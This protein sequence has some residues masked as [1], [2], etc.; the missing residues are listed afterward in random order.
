VGITLALDSGT[1][2]IRLVEVT[3]I[4]TGIVWDTSQ[5]FS[6]F[7]DEN[8]F[9]FGK[10]LKYQ[11]GYACKG[12]GC[13]PMHSAKTTSSFGVSHARNKVESA[14]MRASFKSPEQ[15]IQVQRAVGCTLQLL[16]NL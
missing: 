11:S 4:E 13:N 6:Y 15:K 2:L 7:K 16:Q 5:I 10:P 3:W 8:K 9:Y 1:G 14:M 12:T